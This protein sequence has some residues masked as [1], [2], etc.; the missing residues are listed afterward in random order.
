MRTI[1][2][3]EEFYQYLTRVSVL[4]KTQDIRGT[5]FPLYCIYDK[6]IDE[7]VKFINCFFTEDA[8]S[9]HMIEFG[10]QLLNPFTHIRSAA[11]N[12]EMS[13]LMKFIV[14]LDE[15]VLETHNNLGYE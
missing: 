15:L 10:E 1:E 9:K 12:E 5:S 8:M 14:S 13:M 7:T 2:I 6:Q 4:M 3:S 11:Y